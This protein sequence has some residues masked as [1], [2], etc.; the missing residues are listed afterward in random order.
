MSTTKRIVI[1]ANSIKHDPGRCIAGRELSADKVP[2]IGGWIRPVSTVGEGEL[3][4]PHMQVSDG[5]PISVLDIFDVPLVSRG[6]DPSQPENWIIDGSVRWNRVGRWPV[7][8]LNELAESPVD[9]W[10]QPGSKLDRASAEFIGVNPPIQ[11]LYLLALPKAYIHRNRWN[12]IRLSFTYAG[13]PYDLSVTDPLVR[14]RLE[15]QGD[16]SY[17][18]TSPRIC[19]SLAPAFEGN[20]YKIVATIIE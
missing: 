12:K 15:R 19:V 6:A 13:I 16:D 2:H 10:C 17:E 3:R 1:L 8:R 11:S 20:H 7:D 4:S 14:G 9:I 18:V 5:R